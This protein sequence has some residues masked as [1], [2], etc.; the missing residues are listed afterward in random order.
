MYATWQ[1]ATPVVPVPD[2]VQVLGLKLPIEFV[3]K[4]TDPVGV[5]SVPG[6]VSVTVAV[7]ERLRVEL[8]ST[9]PM[10]VVVDRWPTVTVDVL[11][12]AR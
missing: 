4:L 2:R 7:Q 6:E 11:L 3:V 10:L 9:Q 1:L 12:L 8:V 5:T